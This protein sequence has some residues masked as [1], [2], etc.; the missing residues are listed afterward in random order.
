MPPGVRFCNLGLVMVTISLRPIPIRLLILILALAGIAVL[1]WT[2]ARP[3]I[4]DSFITFVQR[5]QE[6]SSEARLQGAD[7]AIGLAE[8]DPLAHMGRGAVY[9]AAANEEQNEARLKTA[10]DELRTATQ[11]SPED[12]RAWLALG[13]ALDRS[14]VLNEARAALE[15][16]ASLAPRH[17]EPRWALGN[18]LLRSGDREA[19]FAQL[20]LALAGRPSALPLVFDYAWE[21]FQGDGRAIFSALAP[22]GES[23]SQMI[24]LL[25]A[26]NRVP[27]AVAVWREATTHTAAEAQQVSTALFY[28]G[29]MTA[30]YEVWNSA[31]MPDRPTPDTDSLLS[32]SSFENQLSM[33]SKVPFLTWRIA[34]MGGVKV[35]LDRKAPNKGQQSLR[36]GFEV[37]ENIPQTF[38]TQTVMVKPSTAYQLGYAVKTEELRGWSMLTLEVVDAADAGRLRATNEPLPNGNLAWREEQINFTTTAKTEAVTIRFQRQ[39]CPDPPCLLTGRVFFDTF[40]LNEPRK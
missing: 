37:R 31:P 12:Y 36:V 26:R 16:S 3:A 39:P 6:L 13:R 15:R 17:F 22:T 18:H 7:T 10:L 38:F 21:A 8:R 33:D 34:P 20:R 2:V 29:E 5:S 1:I 32:N 9:L 14:G 30:A 11:I 4:G 25:V 28:A 35:S 19:S 23:R 40:R 27:D 24:A